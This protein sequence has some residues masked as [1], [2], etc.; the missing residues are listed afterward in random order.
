MVFV[1]YLSYIDDNFN[2]KAIG[3]A[4]LSELQRV[5][6]VDFIRDNNL[7]EKVF[8][9]ES[10]ELVKLKAWTEVWDYGKTIGILENKNPLQDIP[11]LRKSLREWRYRISAHKKLIATS[12]EGRVAPLCE[13][14][15]RFWVLL[16]TVEGIA[17]GAKVSYKLPI[18]CRNQTTKFK[19]SFK[20]ST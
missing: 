13:A 6:I 2:D 15:Q 4:Y 12:G 19:N 11:A 17:H 1:F 16:E 9:E 5:K 10:G 3:K 14:D 7:G 8:N 18:N 20:F